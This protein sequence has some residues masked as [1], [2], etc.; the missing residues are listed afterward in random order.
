MFRGW[1]LAD[2]LVNGTMLFAAAVI[3]Y[4]MFVESSR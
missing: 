2:W 3:L 4:G 1:T